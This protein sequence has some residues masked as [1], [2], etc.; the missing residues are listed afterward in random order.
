MPRL[1]LSLLL[2]ACLMCLPRVYGA[3]VDPLPWPQWRGPTR[4]GRV[5]GD[6][7][8]D[9]L[10]SERL[11][12]LWR[13]ESSGPSFSGPIVTDRVVF[14]TE[15][16]DE[17]TEHATA[18]DRT[19]GKVVWTASW[20]G[21]MQVVAIGRP[22]GSWI[23][24][25][26]ACDGERLYV[27]SMRDVLVCLDAGT[28]KEVWRVDFPGEFQTRLP[29]FGGVSS[30]LVLGDSVFVQAGEGLAKIERRTGKVLWRVLEKGP[31]KSRNGAFSSL[32]VATLGGTE[33][34]VVQTREELAVVEPDSGRVTWSVVTPSLFGMNIL[35]PSVVGEKVFSS[36]IAGSFLLAAT[37]QTVGERQVAAGES[38]WRNL[39]QGF[40]ASPVVHEG[41]AYLHLRNQ[42]LACIDLETGN[43]T[44]A[45][46]PLGE[47]VSLVA[48]GDRI[49][50]L[51]D[52]GRLMLMRANPKEFDLLGEAM[53]GNDTWGWAHLAIANGELYVRDLKGLTALRWK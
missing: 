2:L 35:T 3:D 48:Q 9:G 31:G 4:D 1:I 20:P 39:S 26:P 44:W 18:F 46:K 14:V 37:P 51:N 38:L 50:V 45:S 41:H 23:R 52:D 19:T 34:L 22:A 25:T 12:R 5:A 6:A 33:R 36:G 7:W 21:A 40:M 47:H 13:V 28:G 43:R 30:P 8:P 53:A 16:R 32:A 17:R 15:T 11:V 49:L 29:D 24:S 27:L 42:R 10:S